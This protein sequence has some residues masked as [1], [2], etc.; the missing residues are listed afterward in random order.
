MKENLKHNI[1]LYYFKFYNCFLLCCAQGYYFF[2]N[3]EC[4][5]A[6]PESHLVRRG[7]KLKNAAI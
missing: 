5:T 3:N 7:A 1:P 4:S 6:A 2:C